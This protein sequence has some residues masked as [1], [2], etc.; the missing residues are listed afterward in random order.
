MKSLLAW[1]NRTSIPRSSIA[2]RIRAQRR[3]SSRVG[4]GWLTRSE[5]LSTFDSCL[6]ADDV[7]HAID[8]PGEEPADIL[9]HDRDCLGG[10]ADVEARHVRRDEY[11]VH[12]PQRVSLGQR[13]LGE[14]VERGA[15]DPASMEG[16]D[17]CRFVDDPTAGHVDEER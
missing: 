4:S 5:A 3:S 8:V 16:L 7:D 13:L 12:R 14:D 15:G 10:I 17:Q 9:Y 1:A 2:A 11:V 6:P